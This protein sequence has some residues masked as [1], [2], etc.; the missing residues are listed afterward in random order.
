MNFLKKSWK[1]LLLCLVIALPS[2]WL[3]KLLPVVG[4]PVFAILFGMIIAFI[5]KQESFTPGINFTSKKILQY[6]IVLLGFDMNLFHILTV[7]RQSL[8]IIISTIS[9]ALIVAY[10]I[11]K[12]LKIPSKTAVLVGVGSSI[13]GGS[14]IAATAPVI[15]AEDEDVAKSISTIFLFNVIAAFIFPALGHLIGMTDQGFGMWA[16]TAVNDTSSV[17]AAATSWSNAAGNDTALTLATIVKLTR[18]LAIIPITFILAIYRSKKEK[19]ASGGAF[20]ISKIFP[21]FVLF[22]LLA[23]VIS[24]VFS[25]PPTVTKP[26]VGL[27]KFMITMAMA[28][29][30]LNT[31]IVHLIKNGGKPIFL[32]LCCWIA[33][34][35]V[36]I[37]M[38]HVLHIW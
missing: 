33:V 34:A 17:V 25:M 9:V 11:S 21:W 32:G 7:G 28:A 15:G 5:P 1:G 29:I 37:L 36:S 35:G 4:G 16:G 30:G 24:T 2:W 38:Q 3:G 18:T 27:G 14:A 13:C 6:A 8:L 10:V 22:F 26:I 12:A 19:I 23:A 31:N 20:K